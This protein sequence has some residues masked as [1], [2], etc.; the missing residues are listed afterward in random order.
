VDNTHRYVPPVPATHVTLPPPPAE[1]SATDMERCREI[2]RNIRAGLGSNTEPIEMPICEE[3]GAIEH[4]HLC[5]VQ[6]RTDALE[7]SGF[8]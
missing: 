6:V 4:D 8:R 2:A 1:R 7:R 3:C 5:S